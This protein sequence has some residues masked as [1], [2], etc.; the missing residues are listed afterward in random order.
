MV[1]KFDILLYN[2]TQTKNLY[3]YFRNDERERG[4]EGWSLH[5]VF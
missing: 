5:C 2:D 4:D 3:A 1:P